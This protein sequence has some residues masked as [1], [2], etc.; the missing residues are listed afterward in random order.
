MF[1]VVLNN[2]KNVQLVYS[3]ANNFFI[4]KKCK[5]EKCTPFNLLLSRPRKTR[6]K[7]LKCN[8]LIVLFKKE[9]CLIVKS[10]SI[11]LTKNHILISYLQVLLKGLAGYMYMVYVFFGS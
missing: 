6:S 9:I 2:N 7:K 5:K 4:N 1:F 3:Y 11:F 8:C 10:Y